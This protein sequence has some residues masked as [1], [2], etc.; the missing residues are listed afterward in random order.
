MFTPI[1][2]NSIASASTLLPRPAAARAA[3]PAH[4][5]MW[6][7]QVINAPRQTGQHR[8][9]YSQLASLNSDIYCI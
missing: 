4:I 2:S 3:A 9:V 8:L 7:D 5:T 1:L 6:R